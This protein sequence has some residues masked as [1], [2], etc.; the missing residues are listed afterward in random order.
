MGKGA[1]T[2]MASPFQ[3]GTSS[4]PDSP[5]L[6]A[7]TAQG[8]EVGNRDGLKEHYQT[9]WHLHNLKRKVA[10]LPLLT[11]EQ[12]ARR[13]AQDQVNAAKAK[14]VGKEAKKMGRSEKRTEIKKER[15]EQHSEK[16]MSKMSSANRRTKKKQAQAALA[17]KHALPGDMPAAEAEDDEDDEMD[18]SDE[19]SEDEEDEDEEE[20]EVEIIEGESLF[21]NELFD[22]WATCLEYM[23]AI[24]GFTIPEIDRVVDMEG[25]C[26]YLQLKINHCFRCL[27]STKRFGSR[28][29]VK[30]FMES[31][32]N[33]RFNSETHELEFGR[34]YDKMRIFGDE[35][36]HNITHEQLQESIEQGKTPSG[37]TMIPR[38]LSAYYKQKIKPDE[39]R[40]AVLAV[41]AETL[42]RAVRVLGEGA[43][44]STLIAAGPNL[45]RKGQTA[46]S[47]MTMKSVNKIARYALKRQMNANSLFQLSDAALTHGR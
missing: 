46:H 35:D 11:R 13:Q 18:W 17:N 39:S 47:E 32:G 7:V 6:R 14:P 4:P 45:F 20:G 42:E 26:Q 27:Y 19:L 31:K 10:G 15:A 37:K 9:E 29:A 24:Y 5:G 40:T 25:M 41:Q 38:E 21:D 36:H 12:F 44:G 1:N 8:G 3:S 2:I 34:F 23:E 22:D 33:R 16:I 43:T 30:H 28:E